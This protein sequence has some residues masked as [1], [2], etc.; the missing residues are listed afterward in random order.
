MYVVES[1]TM[2]NVANATNE[3]DDIFNMLASAKRQASAAPETSEVSEELYHRGM[4]RRKS[5]AQENLAN[6]FALPPTPSDSDDDTTSSDDSSNHESENFKQEEQKPMYTSRSSV[7]VPSS[8]NARAVESEAKKRSTRKISFLKTRS[9][10]QSLNNPKHASSRFRQMG[11]RLSLN[12]LMK[13]AQEDGEEEATNNQKVG[14]S[15]SR[16][17]SLPTVRL[18]SS[19]EVS[20]SEPIHENIEK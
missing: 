11:R 10:S 4:S 19:R 7:R 1:V 8:D 14:N 3:N 18:Q 12:N 13:P 15:K 17:I 16:R 20:K 6:A 5:L 2:L 9:S